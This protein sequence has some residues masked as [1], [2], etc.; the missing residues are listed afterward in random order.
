MI[1]PSSDHEN[2]PESRDILPTFR[3]SKELPATS[4]PLPRRAQF[5]RARDSGARER[6]VNRA[7][8]VS[9]KIDLV[10]NLIAGPQS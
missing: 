3:K 9:S 7:R 5:D 6:H 4:T 1:L 10:A 8:L 2:Y